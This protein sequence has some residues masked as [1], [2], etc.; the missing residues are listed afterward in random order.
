MDKDYEIVLATEEDREEILSLYKAQIG[1]EYCPWDEHYPSNES[2]DYDFSRDA[3]FVLKM[4]G[5]VKAAIS[6]EEDEAVDA[7]GCWDAGLN[8]EGELA[9]LAVLPE[10][11]SRGLG[12]IMLQFGMDELKR[13]GYKGIHILVNKYNAKAIKCYAVFGFRVAGECQMYDQD[14]LC[15]EKELD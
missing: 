11:Q 2:I 1:R 14:F 13:R 10:E 5:K 8:P 9:R 3:L 7:L 4:D 6:V 15:Y 12:R